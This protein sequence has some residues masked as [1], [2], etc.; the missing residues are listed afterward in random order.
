MSQ[1]HLYIKRTVDHYP[2]SMHSW[3]DVE[4]LKADL[5]RTDDFEDRN[6]KVVAWAESDSTEP[7]VIESPVTVSIYT[8]TKSK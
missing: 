6:A 2:D 8:Y 4:A 7:L 5:I 3:S 1:I